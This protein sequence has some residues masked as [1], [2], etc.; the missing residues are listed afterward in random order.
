MSKE[1][2]PRLYLAL[3]VVLA[4]FSCGDDD[5]YP[6][7]E[8]ADDCEVPEGRS[9]ECLPKGEDG[10]CTWK[11]G[12]DSEC[13]GAEDG[14]RVCAPFESTEEQYCFPPCDGDACPEGFGCRS[15]GGGNE[16]RKICFPDAL[17]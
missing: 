2:R 6:P 1:H 9:A 4:A 10:F 15:T 3:L 16:N 13:D 7:C 12:A 14:A 17:E 8:V 5:L 11:C